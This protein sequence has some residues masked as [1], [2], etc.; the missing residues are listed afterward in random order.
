MEDRRGTNYKI[1]RLNCSFHY[2]DGDGDGD[3]KEGD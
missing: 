3:G 1:D 2:A